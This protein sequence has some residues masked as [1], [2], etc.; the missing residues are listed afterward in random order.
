MA[1]KFGTVKKVPLNAF[2]RP[3]TNGIIA[4]DLDE[5]DRLVGVDITDATKDIMLFSDAGKV[6]RFDENLKIDWAILEKH[7][8]YLL[9]A[10]SLQLLIENCFKHNSMNSKNP[11]LIRIESN[12]KDYLTVTNSIF[13]KEHSN[14]STGLGLASLQKRYQILTQKDITILKTETNFQVSLPLFTADQLKEN[15]LL[16]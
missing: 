2:C 14:E 4:V 13:R 7:L 10:H 5:G 9:P 16:L 8:T 6:I 12:D 1:T 15:K 11:L 3:R